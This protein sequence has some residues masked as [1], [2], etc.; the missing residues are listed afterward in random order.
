MGGSFF[1][2]VPRW[3]SKPV[4]HTAADTA[5]TPNLTRSRLLRP[6]V[7]SSPF[8]TEPRAPRDPDAETAE[9]FFPVLLLSVLRSTPVSPSAKSPFPV[10]MVEAVAV[11]AS[12]RE[13]F[14]LSLWRNNA[15]PRPTLWLLPLLSD[16][17]RLS[18]PRMP[19]R[20]PA[21]RLESKLLDK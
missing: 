11:A 1:S 13:S 17:R 21:R 4:S 6:L 3:C 7:V 2:L 19:P 5:T 14:V 18:K 9:L 20:L 8:T 12:D 16:E 10:L 15:R